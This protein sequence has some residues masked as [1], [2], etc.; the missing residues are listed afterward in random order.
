V[1]HSALSIEGNKHLAHKAVELAKET[2]R[3]LAH[4]NNTTDLYRRLQVFYHQFLTSAVS[5]LFLASTHAPLEFSSSCRAEFYMALEL[6]KGLSSRSW[7]SQRLW[8]TVRSLKAYAQ[9][10]GM[11]DMRNS[12]EASSTAYVLGGNNSQTPRAWPAL[13]GNITGGRADVRGALHL[14]PFNL[15]SPAQTSQ[16]GADEDSNINGVRLRSEIQR[17]FEGYIIGGPSGGLSPAHSVFTPDGSYMTDP[18]NVSEGVYEQM[19]DMF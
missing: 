2:I 17:I 1:L 12:G 15:S 14:T 11:E 9:R 6:I 4:L 5:V 16:E 13:Y 10:V 8:R 3:S 18:D 19:R 7:V